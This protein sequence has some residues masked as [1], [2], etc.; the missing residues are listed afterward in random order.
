MGRKVYT[1]E[2]VRLLLKSNKRLAQ[3]VLRGKIVHAL[4]NDAVVV[5]QIP[6]QV[7]ERIVEVIDGTDTA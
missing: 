7:L 5:T 4:L 1:P 6:F 3:D 2:Q